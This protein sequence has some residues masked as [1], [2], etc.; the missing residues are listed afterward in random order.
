MARLAITNKLPSGNFVAYSLI[1]LA[2]TFGILTRII[3]LFRYTTFDIGQA[4]DQ[5]RDAFVYMKM[6]AGEFP[7]LG[8]SSSVG[9]YSLPPLYYYLVFPAVW[10]GADPSLQV[11]PNG[12]FS[13]LAI[14]LFMVLIYELLENIPD[15]K[16]LLLS[17]VAGLWYSLIFSEV[18]VSTFEWNISPIP[19]FLFAFSL[20]YKRLLEGGKSLAI[21]A[22]QWILY[23]IS[24]AV[25]ICL[26]S[27]TLF[28]MPIVF[29]GSLLVFLGK[30][31]KHSN[32]WFLPGLAI[33]SAIIT[34]TPYWIGEI[35][36]R[37]SNTKKIL[38][39][40][41]NRDDQGNAGS[42]IGY[43]LSRIIFNYVELGQQT[44]FTK[45]P[46][47]YGSIGIVFLAL[48][49][50]I[51]ITKFRGNKTLLGSLI[52]I[53]IIYLYAASNYQKEYFFHYKMLIFF[54]P[55]LFTV[56]TL[57]YIDYQRRFINQL[58]TGFLTLGI[59]TS[60]MSNLYFNYLYLDTKF[61]QEQAIAI[62]DMINI[63]NQLPNDSTI[64]DPQYIRL[65]EQYHI[66]Q[67][68]DRYITK[69]NF[70]LSKVCES[71]NYRIYPKFQYAFLGN[72]QWPH[73]DVISPKPF[74]QPAEK[75]LE[76]PVA[77][78]YQIKN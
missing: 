58:I 14:L 73:F 77:Y 39:L 43:R 21:Q 35:S 23:G 4:P 29:I 68:L 40:I 3:S 65:R 67:Y 5:I 13:F 9:N 34:L 37:G 19:F 59:F 63:L 25:L 18:F 36:R 24:L 53:W 42:S 56:L 2:I 72:N 16:R 20:L 6:L 64:C 7:T 70:K 49:L 27:T 22:F 50:I 26:H 33:A 41:F 74:E 17:G 45:F 75:F 12:I 8:Q 47:F 46:W 62:P 1:G 30:N 60:C 76:L 78:I 32:R 38:A 66:V 69:K 31:R 11:F 55:I 71:G 10:F 28:V 15:S 48:I 52:S 61:G 54:A 44:Y 51:G 57:A